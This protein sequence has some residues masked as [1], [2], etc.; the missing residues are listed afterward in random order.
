MIPVVVEFSEEIEVQMRS[1]AIFLA[2]MALAG[3]Q[4]TGKLNY[5]WYNLRFL[6]TVDDIR[7]WGDYS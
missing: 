4:D 6:A 5:D 3:L 1:E 2:K 7:G